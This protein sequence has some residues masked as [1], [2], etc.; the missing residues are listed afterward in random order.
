MPT[1]LLVLSAFVSTYS[2]LM[3]VLVTAEILARKVTKNPQA[4]SRWL[5]THFAHNPVRTTLMQVFSGLAV[6]SWVAIMLPWI[7]FFT[8]QWFVTYTPSGG[9]MT[10]FGEV[11][12]QTADMYFLVGFFNILTAKA[13]PNMIDL[14]ALLRQGP[15]IRIP[16]GILHVWAPLPR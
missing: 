3:C 1:T 14:F 2:V 11:N 4:S 7:D 10:Y 16:M 8:V 13:A 5:N 9:L 6:L 12:G 15:V